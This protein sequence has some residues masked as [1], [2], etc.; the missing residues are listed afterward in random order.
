MAKRP[1]PHP[2]HHT[3]NVTPA[4]AREIQEQL[5]SRVSQENGPELRRIRYVAGVDCSLRD[6]L[7]TAAAPI[8]RWDT[9]EQ[10]DLA[11]I[12]QPSPFPYVPGL[13]SF[14]ECP[15]ILVAF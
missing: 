5:R 15:A 1:Q 14:R 6:N 12:Q 8:L 9:L 13:L 3:W 2:L 4:E 10:V 7:A 11:I